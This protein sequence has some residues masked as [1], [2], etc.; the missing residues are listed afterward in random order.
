MAG[1]SEGEKEE[2]RKGRTEGKEVGRDGRNRE[3]G[4]ARWRKA[5]R[6]EERGQKILLR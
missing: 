2:G 6:I 3:G 4:M 5:E 1:G